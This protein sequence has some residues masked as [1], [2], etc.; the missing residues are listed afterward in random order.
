M[1]IPL[2]HTDATKYEVIKR[3]KFVENLTKI[4]TF[5]DGRNLF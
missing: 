4:M 2:T 5:E 3:V 1:D